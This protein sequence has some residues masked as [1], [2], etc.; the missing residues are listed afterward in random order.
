MRCIPGLTKNTINIRCIRVLHVG[1]GH[2]Q[3]GGIAS[4]L[5]ELSAQRA[6]FAEKAVHI[7]FAETHGF[8]QVG[9]IGRFVWFD[10]PRFILA[11]R[12]SDIVH[13]HVADRGSFYR[14]SFLCALAKLLRCRV[15]FHLHSG[16]FDRFANT[17]GAV[18]RAII[19]WFIGCADA[20]AGVSHACARVLNDFRGTKGDALVIGNAAVDAQRASANCVF[21]PSFGA[22]PYIAFAGRLT[23]QKGVDTLIDALSMLARNGCEIELHL[24]GE[25]DVTRWRAAAE[26]RG[27]ADRVRFL[28]WLDGADKARFYQGATVFCLPSQ[29]ES[30]G[31]VA[32]EAMFHGVP[33][34]SSRVGGLSELVDDGVTGILVESGDAGALARS[35]QRIVSDALL[36]DRM[37]AAGRE[38]A[39]R[40]YTSEAMADRYVDC[41]RSIV[42]GAR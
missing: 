3:R 19:R 18:T 15:V 41:Y 31:I 26:A 8:R 12:R 5:C 30:F 13:F 34:V 7:S 25:G 28:G 32:L 40:F 22:R 21:L 42:R 33:V 9:G 4:V 35:L 24:A 36:R 16:N 27:I 1:P 37:G 17:S 39:T 29:F 14:K 2:G 23:E 10:V 11:A 38:R 6:M 20:A